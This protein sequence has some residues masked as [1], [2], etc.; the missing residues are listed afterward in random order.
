MQH[1]GIRVPRQHICTICCTQLE[2]TPMRENS[3]REA[4]LTTDVVD[5]CLPSEVV[6]SSIEHGRGGR[7]EDLARVGAVARVSSSPEKR[8]GVDAILRRRVAVVLLRTVAHLPH[9]RST[10]PKARRLDV[11]AHERVA[12]VL[13]YFFIHATSS[14][15]LKLKHL[16]NKLS[17]SLEW[18]FWWKRAK[19]G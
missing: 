11:D 16:W 4:K 12:F 2:N 10:P 13:H 6:T 17:G 1:R 8:G 5:P 18:N 14:V 15:W 7:D 9:V 19:R 3:R